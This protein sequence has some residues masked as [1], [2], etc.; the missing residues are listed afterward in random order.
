ML[1][2]LLIISL[3]AAIISTASIIIYDHYLVKE[4]VIIKESRTSSLVKSEDLL[5]NGNLQR[6]FLSSAPT[7]FIQA[8]KKATPAVVYIRASNGDSFQNMRGYNNAAGSGVIISSDGYIATNNHVIE[9]GTNITVVLNDRREFSAEIIGKDPTTDLALLKIE[10]SELP[11]LVFG[12]SDSL[13]VGEW[14]LAVGNPFRLQSTVTAGI[15]SAKGRNINILDTE[16]GIESFIQTDA[17]VNPGN[18]GGALV[19]TNGELVGINTA[20]ITYSGRYEG[21]SFA[22]PA[23]LAMKVIFDLKEFGAVHRGLLGITAENLSVDRARQLGL[24]S[25]NGVH[26]VRVSPESGAHKAGIRRG[27]VILRIQGRRINTL[28]EMLEI[29]GRFR[30]GD[31]VEVSYYRNGEEFTTLSILKNQLNTTDLVSVR[32]DKI[33]TDLGFEVRDLLPSEERRLGKEGGVKVISIYRGSTIARTKMEPGYIITKM[34]EQAITSA[35]QLVKMLEE[36]RGRIFFEGHYEK[37]PGPWWYAFH[38]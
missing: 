22:I 19:N 21:Y 1:Y 15:V 28:P 8:A 2:K 3:I 4:T 10:A 38:R 5:L 14:V 11:Y 18:S 20:I 12:N 34:N 33:L 9:D 25:P 35:D 16:Y 31:E 7:N 24:P 6:H 32:K 23:N 17:A 37:Y 26:V 27:D 30:P 36:T 13:Q 29:L